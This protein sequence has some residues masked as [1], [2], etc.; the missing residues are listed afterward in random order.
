MSDFRVR[1]N[2]VMGLMLE[3]SIGLLVNTIS[4]LVAVV[5]SIM[6]LRMSGV[7][8]PAIVVGVTRQ[9]R[10]VFALIRSSV[11]MVVPKFKLNRMLS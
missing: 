6:V 11:A 2:V 1:V 8:I 7:N 9:Y 3:H 4:L 5:L 10:V